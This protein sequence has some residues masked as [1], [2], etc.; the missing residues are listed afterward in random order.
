MLCFAEY[1]VFNHIENNK[2]TIERQKKKIEKKKINKV[3]VGGR[4][5]GRGRRGDVREWRCDVRDVLLMGDRAP[6]MAAA[7]G[8]AAAVTMAAV[9][10]AAAT[11]NEDGGEGGGRRR[12]SGHRPP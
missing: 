4:D 12:G 7:L 3:G 9:T 6:V 10:M 11:G 2:T 1:I 5:G 8:T